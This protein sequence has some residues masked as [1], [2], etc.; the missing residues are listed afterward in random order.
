MS[1]PTNTLI[2]RP[3]KRPH[4]KVRPFFER[5][6][7]LSLIHKIWR[8]MEGITSPFR[9]HPRAK[10]CRT[11]V[12]VGRRVGRACSIPYQ[13]LF[14]PSLPL[15]LL[16][17]ASGRTRHRSNRPHWSLDPCRSY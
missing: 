16:V 9:L 1:S 5:I 3:Q 14:A 10:F 11:T 15:E 12:P 2:A 17:E 4:T 8:Q 7:L 6:A 13:V